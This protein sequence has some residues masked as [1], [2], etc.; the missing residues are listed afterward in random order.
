MKNTIASKCVNNMIHLT[1]DNTITYIMDFVQYQLFIQHA[2]IWTVKQND[3]YH[4]YKKTK[5]TNISLL[6]YL[7][8]CDDT[9]EFTF[10]NN[11][12]YDFRIENVHIER[13]HPKYHQLICNNYNV[14]D[15]NYGHYRH[16]KYYNQYWK[17][18][19]N[20]TIKYI[21]YCEI[22]H[23]IELTETQFNKIIEYEKNTSYKLTLTYVYTKKYWQ[24]STQHN[25]IRISIEKIINDININNIKVII[26]NNIVMLTNELQ[27]QLRIQHY[28]KKSKTKYYVKKSKR[29]NNQ[30]MINFEK[31]LKNNYTILKVYRGH[32]SRQGKSANVEKNRIWKLSDINNK[33]LYLMFCEPNN[34]TI[35]CKKSIKKI[36]AYEK[37]AHG[38]KKITWHYHSTGYINGSDCKSM[39][40]VIMNHFGNGKGTQK[41]SVDHIDRNPLNNIYSN[42]RIATQ[43]EQVDN[44]KS[45]QDDIKPERREDAQPLPEGMIQG[46][47]STYVCYCTER[48]TSGTVR[49]YF[50]VKH[51]PLQHG[52]QYKTTTKQKVSIFTKLKIAN[53]YVARLNEQMDIIA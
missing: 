14:I 19:Q 21:I 11:N 16:K 8:D 15:F 32:F 53:D 36:R 44:T 46:M 47:M 17:I 29:K 37:D 1:I 5:H 45:K 28:Q 6:N 35:L 33:I 43:D 40:Q 7:Y 42:L 12:I 34:F 48:C 2:Y 51:H 13:K 23:L 9:Y 25:G 4:S 24:I 39:H 31:T 18:I 26:D 20:N 38:N 3:I 49:E 22:D 10:I 41:T 52:K 50:T 30:E 27:K